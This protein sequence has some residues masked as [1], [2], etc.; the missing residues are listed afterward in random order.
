MACNNR[1]RRKLAIIIEEE[2]LRPAVPTNTLSGK[3][4]GMQR[5]K[6]GEAKFFFLSLLGRSEKGTT[7][8]FRNT[9]E[10]GG[11][12][13]DLKKFREGPWLER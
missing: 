10:G 9:G 2:R 11:S 6:R 1:P 4:K 12:G 5:R 8:L 3:K 13:R 7:L